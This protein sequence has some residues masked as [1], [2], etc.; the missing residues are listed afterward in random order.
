MSDNASDEEQQQQMQEIF[1]CADVWLEVFAFVGPLDVGL[2]MALISDRLDILVDAHFKLMKRLL[3]WLLIRRADDGNGAQIVN[4]SSGERLPIPQEPLP[5]KVIGFKGIWI[6]YVD[7][8]VIEFLQRIRHLFDSS[9]TNLEIE[10]DTSDDQSR[11]WEIIW[12]KIWPLVNNN[13]CGLHL[14]DSQCDRLRQFC[15]TILR[16]CAQLRSIHSYRLFPEFPGEDNAGA[17]S[18]QA[19][20]KWLITPRGDGLPKMLLC[21]SST[22]MEGLK[23]TFVNAFEPANFIIRLSHLCFA[24]VIEPFELKNNWTGESLTFRRINRHNLLL[25]RCPIAR[26]E[27]KWAKWEKE[28]KGWQWDHQLNRIAIDFN[29]S[30]IGDGKG[31]K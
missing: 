24:V 5:N 7:Q 18:R 30:D 2:K 23:R 25:V 16:N 1:I 28:A 20:A 31:T 3:G 13:T 12:Q 19:L 22:E 17:S 10:M 8:T 4:N 15:P 29:D 27:D 21:G 11:S 14:C 26:E 9:G 6:R